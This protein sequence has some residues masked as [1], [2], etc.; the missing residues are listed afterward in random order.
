MMGRAWQILGMQNQNHR[1]AG[2]VSMPADGL[3]IVSSD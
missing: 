2:S 1:K 3:E